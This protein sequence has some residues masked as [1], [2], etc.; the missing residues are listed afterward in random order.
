M[1]LL[2]VNFKGH[3]K[4]LILGP[5]F[6]LFEAILEL[7]VPLVMAGIIDTGVANRD[8]A[9][10][11]RG[12]LLLLGLAVL[13]AAAGLTCQ[14]FAAVAAGHFGVRLRR[15]LY[16]HALHLG[17]AETGDYGAGALITRLTNDTIQIQTGVNMFIRLATRVP[18]LAI[19]SIV[20]ALILNPTIGV[21]Y[22]VATP[23]IALVLYLVMRQTLPKYG[24]IQSKQD[25]LSRLATENLDGVRVIRA[26]SRQKVETDAFEATGDDMRNL[27][28]RVGRL[29][30]LLNP[31]TSVIANLAVILIVWM[32]ASF[33]FRGTLQPGEIIAL[34]N[35]MM[36]I[37]LALIVAVNLI[38]I[39]TRGLASAKRVAKLLETQPSIQDGPGA[40]PVE[41]APALVFE[42]VGYTYKDGAEEVLE[43]ISFSVR[44]GETVGIIGGT[45]SGKSTLAALMMRLYD[46]T[47]GKIMVQG[48]AIRTY[49]L[50]SLRSMF[51]YVPQKTA[52]FSGTLRANLQVSNPA[53]TDE[54]M[55]QALRVAQAEQFVRE[56]K[57]GLDM[58]LQEGSGN[59]S[60]GQRQRLTIA[61]ALVRNPR[62]L[63]LDDASSA[64]DYTT[65]WNLR[66][67]LSDLK[68]TMNHL[69][70][71][72]IIS[73]RVVSIKDADT[74]LVL[75]DG[76][77]VGVG[78]HEELLQG[79]AV[80]AEICGSQGMAVD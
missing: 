7:M 5:L 31:V 50:R 8:A 28:V 6:K 32:G 15:Q 12:G 73:Q 29:S 61:R 25:E 16:S 70:T 60:G 63:I 18:Y 27:V 24:K 54:E 21:V 77:L 1:K 53:A 64:L 65:E 30:A 71:T 68:K 11:I 66:K 38:I 52:L 10:V 42:N 80:Y 72:V 36:Q 74:I 26:F 33:V 62:I 51:G 75:D 59:L 37:L 48:Q 49:K 22:L 78:T 2:T 17:L 34:V 45:G 41:E 4:E 79:N 44:A 9:Y 20:M 69:M 19:G 40:E 55:W 13:G 76:R 56:N 46:T 43:S 14:Y 3:M 47:K 39:F 57:A 58:E 23:L 67:A 35:Y